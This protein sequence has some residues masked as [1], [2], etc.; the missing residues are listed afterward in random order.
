LNIF[1]DVPASASLVERVFSIPH[2]SL[3]K[4]SMRLLAAFVVLFSLS[5]GLAT[6]ADKTGLCC[7]ST[8]RGAGNIRMWLVLVPLISAVVS[9]VAAGVV[10][11]VAISRRA[12]RSILM[13]LPLLVA[14][15]VLLFTQEGTNPCKDVKGPCVITTAPVSQP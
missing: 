13:L 4:W 3:G 14:A 9:A 12:E 11:L 10:A 2:T 15:V 1:S 5:I 6:M 7:I 8:S